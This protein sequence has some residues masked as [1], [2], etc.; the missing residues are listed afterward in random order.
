MLHLLLGLCLS[1]VRCYN[2][3][4][5]NHLTLYSIKECD[6]Y[7]FPPQEPLQAISQVVMSEN[8]TTW[9]EIVVGMTDLFLLLSHHL[10]L[11][12]LP[13][14]PLCTLQIFCIC[15]LGHLSEAGT[16]SGYERTTVIVSLAA[17]L[18]CTQ[19]HLVPSNVPGLT[20]PVAPSSPAFVLA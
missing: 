18:L 3:S 20:W 15:V 9:S 16:K 6:C 5:Q 19:L 10:I 8:C 11:I 7:H 12:Q 4:R 13:S 17:R 1:S 2:Q 14:F